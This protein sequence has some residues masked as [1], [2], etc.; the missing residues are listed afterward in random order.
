MLF[1]A[2]AAKFYLFFCRWLLS[3]VTLPSFQMPL[4]FSLWLLI[5]KKVSARLLDNHL[6]T[7]KKRPKDVKAGRIMLVGFWSFNVLSKKMMAIQIKSLSGWSTSIIKFSKTYIFKNI[8]T[9]NGLNLN[10]VL[11]Q[12]VSSETILFWIWKL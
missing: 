9:P 4:R 7:H 6:P 1:C 3:W 2:V 12:I 5:L 8:R 11:P 10:T